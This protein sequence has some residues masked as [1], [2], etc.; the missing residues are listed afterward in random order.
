VKTELEIPIDEIPDA[1]V[2]CDMTGTIQE[3]NTAFE[4]L[5]GYSAEELLGQK[6]EK[7]VPVRFSGHAQMREAYMK[8]P[9]SRPMGSVQRIFGQR[10]N[11]TEVPLDISLKRFADGEGILCF[12]RDISEHYRLT[13][14]IRKSAYYDPVTGVSNRRAFNEDLADILLDS[15]QVC[16][17]LFDFDHFK[18][19]NDTLGH[20]V[21][22]KLLQAFCER[23]Q[24]MMRPGMKLYRVGGDEFALVISKC[25]NKQN[26]LAFIETAIWNVRKPLLIE[27][28]EIAIGCSAGIVEAPRDGSTLDELLSNADLALYNAK[29]VRGRASGYTPELRSA[30]EERFKLL[31]ELQAAVQE[32]QFELHYQPQ[33]ET[34]TGK[35][36]GAE[37]LL[38]WRHPRRGLLTPHHFI[39]LLTESELSIQIGRWILRQACREACRWQHL[40][41]RKVKV[42]VNLFPRQ[43][44]SKSLVTDVTHALSD[45]GLDPSCL[46]LELT[47]NTIM[48]SADDVMEVLRYFRDLGIAI[49]LDDFG[50]GYAS[51]KSLTSYPLDTIKVDRS[52]VFDIARRKENQAVLC[53]VIMLARQFGLTSVAEGVETNED[54]EIMQYLGFDLGQGYYWSRPVPAEEFGQLLSRNGSEVRGTTAAGSPSGQAAKA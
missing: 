49:G 28:H 43:T 9:V 39:D 47:E 41:S 3:T 10:K 44:H 48:D 23:M 34:C 52:F 8:S 36:L 14:E 22:D 37:A 32:E 11:G 40:S 24:E 53:A 51:L 38:R 6:I 29:L 2:L 15:T 16:L 12:T 4:V 26:A 7:L 21:G 35:I 50:T 20:S 13:E 54:A 19:V 31:T 46:E 45:S 1:V 25:A 17:G 27:S 30:A 33:I 5:F 18:D 42:A